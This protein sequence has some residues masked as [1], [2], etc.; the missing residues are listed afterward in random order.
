MIR[1][2]L[3]LLFLASKLSSCLEKSAL[4]KVCSVLKQ[5]DKWYKYFTTKISSWGSDK[6]QTRA[7]FQFL[8]VL[9]GLSRSSKTFR[10]LDWL[11]KKNG[12]PPSHPAHPPK[13]T[14]FVSHRL[15]FG[16]CRVNHNPHKRK[17]S[18][19][20]VKKWQQ[21]GWYVQQSILRRSPGGHRSPRSSQVQVTA[22]LQEFL[23]ISTPCFKAGTKISR[24]G[25]NDKL[26]NG[27]TPHFVHVR[28]CSEFKK[29]W[30]KIKSGGGES[31]VFHELSLKSSKQHMHRRVHKNIHVQPHFP[32]WL[33]SRPNE[34]EAP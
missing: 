11:V 26:C 7:M 14:V 34:G 22:S 20:P 2:K 17:A 16:V 10:V 18:R 32:C 19:S 8:R 12:L 25:F 13:G 1:V 6:M 29:E 21:L 3:K 4:N 5:N 27:K 28:L 9:D 24:R 23:T 33:E 31:R 15:V 30:N